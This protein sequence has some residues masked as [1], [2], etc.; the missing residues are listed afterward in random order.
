MEDKK[1]KKITVI[2]GAI[3]TT[4]TVVFLCFTVG[5][6]FTFKAM[7]QVVVSG[8]SMNP[9][10]EN[11]DVGMM[12]NYKDG[13]VIKRWDIVGLEAERFRENSTDAKYIK[14]VVGLPGEEVSFKKED[15]YFQLYIDNKKME[16]KFNKKEFSEVTPYACQEPVKLLS[17]EYF[18]CGDNRE[19]SF[20]SRY[21]G[22]VYDYEITLIGFWKVGKMNGGKVSY[23]FPKKIS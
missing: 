13:D 14:R 15:G 22:C 17:G 16:E 10:L 18:V 20:D 7:T 21:F 11:L 2:V 1:K 12:N 9:T 5:I 8:T 23:S 4:L 3:C 6:Y 19:G